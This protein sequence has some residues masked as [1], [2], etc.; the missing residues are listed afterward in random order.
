MQKQSVKIKLWKIVLSFQFMLALF[1]GFKQ[2]AHLI[3][4]CGPRQNQNTKKYTWNF[5]LK[6]FWFPI[7]A[8]EDIFSPYAFFFFLPNVALA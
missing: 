3:C 2:V 6:H 1:R 7:V 5:G 8:Q 4:L